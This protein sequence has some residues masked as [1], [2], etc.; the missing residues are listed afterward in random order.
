MLSLVF[1]VEDETG[2]VAQQDLSSLE[3]HLY[4]LQLRRAQKQTPI[5]SHFQL[6]GS[7]KSGYR[8]CGYIAEDGGGEGQW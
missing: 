8:E 2:I 6:G 4:I 3:R 7:S 5:T 1:D